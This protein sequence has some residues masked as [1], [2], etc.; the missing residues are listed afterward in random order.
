MEKVG[1]GGW[2]RTTDQRFIRPPLL[3]TEVHQYVCSSVRAAKR[4]F[5]FVNKERSYHGC[6][7]I[8]QR[9]CESNTDKSGQS[10]LHYPLCY[11]SMRWSV[12]NKQRALH[13]VFSSFAHLPFEVLRRLKGNRVVSIYNNALT[14]LRIDPF[15]VFSALAFEHPE[16]VDPN[17][18]VI[19]D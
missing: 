7:R 8:W 12:R 19:K 9:D 6:Q 14:S 11:P 18:L 3:P 2:T 10:R 15:P 13:P 1:T 16:S 4:L 5:R 17:V